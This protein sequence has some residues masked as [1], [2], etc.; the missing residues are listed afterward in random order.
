MT[1][2]P[3]PLVKGGPLDHFH[4]LA[5]YTCENTNENAPPEKNQRIVKLEEYLPG[6]KS[7]LSTPLGVLIKI[8]RSSYKSL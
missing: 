3:P 2:Y 8:K 6:C 4:K 5:F 1:T 7:I